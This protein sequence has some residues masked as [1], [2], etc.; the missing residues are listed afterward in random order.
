MKLTVKNIGIIED[1]NILLKGITVLA[2]ENGTGKSTIS[3]T[4]FSIFKSL[5]NYKKVVKEDKLNEV[6][7]LLTNYLFD[8]ADSGFSF[9]LFRKISE[10]FSNDI[11]DHDRNQEYSSYEIEKK[12][13]KVL[14][15]FMIEINHKQIDSLISKIEVI[16]NQ[17]E[18]S[19]LEQLVGNVFRGE[20]NNQINNIDD[21]SEGKISL[22]LGNDNLDF[23]ATDNIVTFIKKPTSITTDVVYIDDAAANVESYYRRGFPIPV[24]RRNHNDHLKKQLKNRFQNENLTRKAVVNE[25]LQK[26]F[27]IIDSTLGN[28][29]PN[30]ADTSENKQ[31]INIV[32]YSSGMKTFY[33]IKSLLT[34]RL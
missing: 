25:K 18:D 11:A 34:V 9:S 22:K 16:L 32:N 14:D 7:R 8:I 33:I 6:S 17:S 1:A 21:P 19:V 5:Y 15:E 26:I 13:K 4:V 3:K 2:G 23:V 20:F 29:Q 28:L 27:E 31:M 10:K 30:D 24:N 12:L